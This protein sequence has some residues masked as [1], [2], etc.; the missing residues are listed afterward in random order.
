MSV[1]FDKRV[2]DRVR[3]CGA[4]PGSGGN[5]GYLERLVRADLAREEATK[6]AAWYDGR[7]ADVEADEA[8]R[9]AVAEELDETA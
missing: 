4:R 9:I 3:Q 8:E 2:A 7:A 6:L 5:S 1:S